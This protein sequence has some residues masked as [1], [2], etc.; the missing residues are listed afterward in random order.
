MVQY[1]HTNL[2][3][4]KNNKIQSHKFTGWLYN[5]GWNYY[6][7]QL[8][9]FSEVEEGND[10]LVTSPTGSGKTIAGFLPSIINSNCFQRDVLYT[11]YI[12]PL[13]SLSYDIERNLLKPILDLNLNI[14]ISVRTGD[15]SSYKKS[16]QYFYSIF[17]FLTY[18][19]V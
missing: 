5:K 17:F 18:P 3:N 4:I 6:N 19:F 2:N 11:L 9:T 8:K 13:K 7:Y 16:I 15:T 10:V 12:S 14:S 1:I